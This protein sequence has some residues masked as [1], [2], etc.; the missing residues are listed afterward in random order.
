[1]LTNSN[2]GP[3]M[4]LAVAILHL[5]DLALKEKGLTDPQSAEELAPFVGRFSTLWGITDVVNLGG[6]LYS[7]SPAMINPAQEAIEMKVVSPTELEAVGDKG[8]GGYGE[9]MVY[10]RDA[11]GQ[12]TEVWGP[13]GMRHAP[14]AEY[15]LPDKLTRPVREATAAD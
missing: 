1:V 9:N 8:F 11:D 7:L 6:R 3:A 5:I 2:D 14:A 13:S 15:T 4:Q 12:I 10:V